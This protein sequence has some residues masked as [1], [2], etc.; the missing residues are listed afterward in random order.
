[1]TLLRRVLLLVLLLPGGLACR[2]GGG[3]LFGP[4]PPGGKHVLFIG[5]SLTYYHDLPT[6]VAQVAMLSNDTIRVASV[7]KPDYALLDHIA[8]GDAVSVIK[9]EHWDVVVMQQG[10]SALEEGRAW[11]YAG[12]DQLTPL[13]RA[14]GGTPALYE[15]WP[16]S[17]RRFDVSGVRYSYAT[18]AQRVNGLFFPGGTAWQEAWD[19][20]PTLNLYEADGL[21][22]SAVATYLIALVMVEQLT[23]RDVRTI[24]AVAFS[25]GFQLILPETTIRS[26]QA[27]AHAA[28]AR[29]MTP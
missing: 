19:R 18:A 1:M 26:L 28:N 17:A 5:N 25:D 12:V 4:L 15:V 13:I 2:S 21:H 29:G 9:R 16:L 22:P 7:S 20:Q 8:D 10:S 23:G 14:A 11:L 6:T 27:A 24:P 3:G